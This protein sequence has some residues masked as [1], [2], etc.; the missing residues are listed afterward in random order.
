MIRTLLNRFANRRDGVAAVELAFVLPLLLILLLGVIEG[1]RFILLQT[2]LEN[3]SARIGDLVTRPEEL[4]TDDVDRI[5]TAVP[6][7]LRPFEADARARVIVTGVV[8]EEGDSV[9]TVAWRRAGGG[10]LTASSEV[11]PIGTAAAVPSGL[12]EEG[13]EALIVTEFIYD[14]S[15]WLMSF[16]TARQVRHTAFFRPRRGTA[17]AIE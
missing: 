10:S 16:V 3:S 11:G 12:V 14:Y 4:S 2:K 7:M 13:G 17:T 1:G 8:W 15:P 9:P 5:L 6:V